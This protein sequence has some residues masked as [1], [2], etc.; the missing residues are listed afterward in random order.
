MDIFKIEGGVQLHGEVTVSGAKN[1]ALPMMAAAILATGK[2]TLHN[3]PRLH[4]IETLAKILRE[5]GVDVEWAGA[6]TMELEVRDETCTI[7]RYE[8]VRTMR[9]SICVLGPLLARRGHAQVPHPGGCV[10]GPRPIDL[11]I[12][13]MKALGADVDIEHGDVI[14]RALKLF[15]DE[16][17]LGGPRGSTCLGT[18]NVMCA[19]TLAEGVTVIENAACEPEIVAL[20]GMLNTMGAKIEGIGTKRLLIEGVDELHGTEYTV[21]NDRIEAGTFMAAAAITE[22]N[23]LVRGVPREHLG[24]VVDAMRHMDIELIPEQDGI[25]VIGP[26]QLQPIDLVTGPFPALPTDMQAQMM[27]MLALADGISIITERIYPERFMHIMELN[28]MR[29][30]VRKEGSSAIIAGTDYLSGAPVMCSDLRA[31]AA[32][33]VAGLVARGTTRLNRVYH[34]DRGYERIEEKLIKLGARIE[35]LPDDSPP[36]TECE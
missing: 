11:H 36:G 23:V 12:K 10:I 22:G 13:G 16:V 28:R 20:A 33:V 31:S 32:L 5:L 14:A 30:K 9:A 7:A 27:A 29:A 24:A 18:A 4:D 19:A 21:P 15:G 34:I 25:R 6:D 1:A 8:L 26:K 2:V 17:Y 35:R 3:V